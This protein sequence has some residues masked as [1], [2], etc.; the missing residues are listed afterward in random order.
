MSVLAVWRSDFID[1]YY[2]WFTGFCWVFPLAFAI[3][4]A[5]QNI[6]EYP[7]IGFSC[8]VSTPNL[9]TYLFYPTA[10]YMYPAMICHVITIGKMI[11]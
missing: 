7:G 8:L 10:V 3:P 2:K 5:V 11:Q 1:R 6:A 4:V 9:N